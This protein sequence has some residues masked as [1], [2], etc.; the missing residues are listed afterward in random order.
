MLKY[1]SVFKLSRNPYTIN[2]LIEI[3]NVTTLKYSV[4]ETKM[5]NRLKKDFHELLNDILSNMACVV[6]D[7]FN[8]EFNEL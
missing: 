8:I 6:T 1:F 2:W 3:L 4:L 5:D 7:S